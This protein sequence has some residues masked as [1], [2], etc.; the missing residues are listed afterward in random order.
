MAVKKV[1]PAKAMTKTEILTTLAE[2]T[3]LSKKEVASVFDDLGAQQIKNIAQPVQVYRIALDR[4][5]PDRGQ[6]L[7]SGPCRPA[8]GHL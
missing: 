4:A 6:E 2:S 3:G 5:A 8:G 7:A 1:A